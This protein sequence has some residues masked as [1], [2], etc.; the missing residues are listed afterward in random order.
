MKTTKI[1]FEWRRNRACKCEYL[2]CTPNSQ[3]PRKDIK[4]PSAHLKFNDQKYIKKN[5][6]IFTCYSGWYDKV[7]DS[8]DEIKLIILIIFTDKQDEGRTGRRF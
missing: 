7:I 1:N 5:G 2:T 8:M 3:K 6:D 4:S